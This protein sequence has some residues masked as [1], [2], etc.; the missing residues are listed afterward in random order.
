VSIHYNRLEG[1]KWRG[2]QP[3][4]GYRPQVLR[5]L[6]DSDD[7]DKISIVEY[8]SDVDYSIDPRSLLNISF[9]APSSNHIKQAAEK[10]KKSYDS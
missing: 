8:F 5:L 2:G 10:V 4:I 6:G 3:P 9:N 1:E 7:E